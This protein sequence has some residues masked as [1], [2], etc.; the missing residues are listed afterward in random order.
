MGNG[1]NPWAFSLLRYW[2]KA[3]FVPVNRPFSVVDNILN[4]SAVKLSSYFKTG[5]TLKLIDTD[6]KLIKR[7]KTEAILDEDLRI[8]QISID[9]S[10][11]V[12]TRPDGFTPSVDI[13]SHGNNEKYII[14]MD[15]P[16]LSL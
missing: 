5:I 11:L 9:S 1:I 4:F 6:N 7:I 2:L 14:Y 15:I 13:I 3:V 12:N 16:G 8:P 10:G